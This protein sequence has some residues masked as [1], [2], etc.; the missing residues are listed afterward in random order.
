MARQYLRMTTSWTKIFNKDDPRTHIANLSG[1]PIKIKFTDTNQIPTTDTESFTLGGL[2]SNIVTIPTKYVYARATSTTSELGE[3]ILI[4]DSDKAISG[5]DISQIQQNLDRF[6][7]EVMKLSTRVTENEIAHIGA[8]E[9]YYLF[10]RKFLNNQNEV[11]RWLAAANKNIATLQ[12]HMFL[13]EQ[14]ITTHRKDFRDFKYQVEHT[15]IT[16]Y[17]KKIEDIANRI[18]SVSTVASN[19]ATKL[20]EYIPRIEEAWGD[21]NSL[22]EKEIKPMQEDLEALHTEFVALNN[23]IV[24]IGTTH[25]PEEIDEIFTSLMTRMPANVQAVFTT[26]KNLIRAVAVNTSDIAET[27]RRDD[28][29]I[30]DPDE[31]LLEAITADNTSTSV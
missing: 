1:F 13:A 12:L 4:T 26:L 17:D 22:V 29:I 3:T 28:L 23:G 5:T 11:Q 24:Q 27:I 16:N 30:L 14:W 6:Y 19:V 7:V 8:H 18:N 15:A 31:E 21:Y 20:E 9:K 2:I 10:L 25:T